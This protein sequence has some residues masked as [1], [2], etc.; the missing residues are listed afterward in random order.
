VASSNGGT[1]QQIVAMHMADEPGWYFPTWVNNLND[2]T[3]FP[4]YLRAFQNYLSARGTAEGFT[5]IDLGQSSWTDLHPIGQSVGNPAT[6]GPAS[7]QN[8][9]LYYWTMRFFADASADGMQMGDQALEAAV[10]H[11]IPATVNW[12]NWID[13]WYIPS[14]DVKI[15]NNPISNA[16]SAMGA[17]DW[18]RAGRI[19]ANTAWTED[20]F[21][22]MQAN[23]WSAYAAVMRSST[24]SGRQSFGGYVVGPTLGRM[25]AGGKYKVF[26]LMGNGSKYY[27]GYAFGPSF[28]FPGNCWS[29]NSAALL[30]GVGT[31]SAYSEYADANRLIGRAESTLFPGVAE[32]SR[33]AIL[34]PSSS[35]LWDRQYTQPYLHNRALWHPLRGVARLQCHSRLRRRYGCRQRRTGRQRLLRA[36]RYRPERLGKGAVCDRKLDHNLRNT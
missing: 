34:L 29:E 22:D 15:G 9:R 27:C 12:N 26:P 8:R 2:T 20:W 32:R 7:I 36:L 19:S 6:G 28:M 35:T 30:N 24:M 10:G 17:M 23:K 18:M 14:P 11:S 5:S 4:G 16:D 33:I 25:A 21:D 3:N 1:P 31:G 13:R